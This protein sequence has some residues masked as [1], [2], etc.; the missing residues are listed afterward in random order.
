M[1]AKEIIIAANVTYGGITYNTPL[2]IQFKHTG[3]QYYTG[4]RKLTSSKQIAQRWIEQGKKVKLSEGHYFIDRLA[5]PTW[6]LKK[7]WWYI[8]NDGDL[9]TVNRL[10][11]YGQKIY[12]EITKEPTPKLIKSL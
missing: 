12:A 6:E 9:Y 8:N 2:K 1:N 7:D 4:K 5:V 10:S 11:K 3:T